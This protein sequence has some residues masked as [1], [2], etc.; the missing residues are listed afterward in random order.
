MNNLFFLF[1]FVDYFS[2][3]FI[4]F[5]ISFIIV[6]KITKI[7]DLIY[8]FL[9]IQQ[10]DD[11]LKNEFSDSEQN[12]EEVKI[13]FVD[14]VV[15]ILTEPQ[16]IFTKIA[17]TKLS[18]ADWLIPVLVLLVITSISLFVMNT[19]PMIRSEARKTQLNQI[20][21]QFDD[22][23]KENKMTREEADRQIAETTKRIDQ[24]SGPMAT[25]FQS[26]S[27]L[28]FGFIVFFIISGFYLLISKFV[29]K[30][31]GDYKAAMIALSSTYYIAI[32]NI[33][34]AT[35]VSLFFDKIVRDLSV[36]TLLSMDKAT[37]TG[38]VLSKIDLFSIWG[39]YI[40]GV[41]LAILFRRTGQIHK[42]LIAVYSI[43][44]IWSVIIYFLG[45]LNPMFLAFS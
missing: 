37:I 41:G 39:Y 1:L 26:I 45:K 12:Q 3:T 35:I 15:G 31:E 36:A 5:V 14:R 22:L 42:Y 24:F 23:V 33:I 9:R 16:E 43:W 2:F 32:I 8:N 10:M 28:V 4:K 17:Q 21:K 11:E 18:T 40:L 20:E 38:F 34:L 19:N 44:I 29:L 25:V 6:S 27:I 30:G 7:F 13:P